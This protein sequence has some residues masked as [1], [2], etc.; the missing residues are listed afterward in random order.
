MIRSV[1]E[2]LPTELQE[3]ATFSVIG[4]CTFIPPHQDHKNN[5]LSSKALS[6]I[7][8]QQVENCLQQQEVSGFS[9]GAH[10]HTFQSGKSKKKR[11]DNDSDSLHKRLQNGFV[12]TSRTNTYRKN[13][14]G[15]TWI[16]L[17]IQPLQQGRSLYNWVPEMLNLS[18]QGH[19]CSPDFHVWF[20]VCVQFDGYIDSMI[21]YSF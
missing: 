6:T 13:V 8:N 1:T 18:I 4:E 10:G 16:E 7:G 19:C 15:D 20:V 9:K 17:L 2:R 5:S 12:E 11:S 3:R 14:A 21:V